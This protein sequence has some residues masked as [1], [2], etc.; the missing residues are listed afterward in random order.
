[1]SRPF[2]PS[3]FV[4]SRIP[5]FT[6]PVFDLE[7]S[8]T[9]LYLRFLKIISKVI[10]RRSFDSLMVFELSRKSTRYPLFVGLGI[11][12]VLICLNALNPVVADVDY[13]LSYSDPAEDVVKFNETWSNLGT[14]GTQS[15]IDI[16]WLRSLN[17]TQDTVLLRMEFKNNLVLE[18]SNETKYVFRIFTSSDNSTGYNITYINGSAVISNFQNTLSEDMTSN[19]SVIDDN[20]EVLLVEISKDKYLT[21]ITYFNLDGFTWK[22][23][24][25]HTY[26]DYVSEIPGH[27]GETGTVV[28]QDNGDPKEEKGL[29]GDMCGIPLIFILIIII[30]IIIVIVILVKRRI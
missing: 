7:S 5:V 14:V 10:I 8:S 15:L 20:G 6:P 18:M 27:P 12:F 3:S 24:G 4:L 22:E 17:E 23:Q 26:I 11:F 2:F 25:N 9:S 1:M 16:K 30:V 28:D 29:L 13:E 21:N 19:T